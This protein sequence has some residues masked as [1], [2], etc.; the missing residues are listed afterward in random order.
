MQSWLFEF[1]YICP[2]IRLL[3]YAPISLKTNI[4]PV[5]LETVIVPPEDRP[6]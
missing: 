3:E 1:L 5:P 2:D 4:E 6:T